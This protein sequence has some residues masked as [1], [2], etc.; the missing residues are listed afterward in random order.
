MKFS[1]LDIALVDL[2]LVDI[3]LGKD[4]P[5]SSVSLKIGADPISLKPNCSPFIAAKLTINL[6][7]LD[8]TAL[9]HDCQCSAVP[10]L[11]TLAMMSTDCV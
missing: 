3:I 4:R 8:P 9:C 11:V 7:Y 5:V 10:C 2:K 1:E 6:R